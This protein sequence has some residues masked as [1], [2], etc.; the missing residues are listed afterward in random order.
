[1]STIENTIIARE[2][3][4]KKLLKDQKYNIDYYQREY[5]W[6]KEQITTLIDDLMEEFNR[7]YDDAHQRNNVQTYNY[8]YMGAVIFIKR[9]EDETA[10]IDGQQRLTSFTLLL[11]YL[12]H[13]LPDGEKVS[14]HDYIS[15]T[16]YGEKLFNLNIPSRTNCLEELLKNGDY[17]VRNDDDDSIQ[18]MMDRY[19][20]IVESESLPKEGDR[21][22]PFF[23]DW[24]TNKVIFVDIS[25]FKDDNAYMIFETMNDRG[26]GL[27]SVEMLKGYMIANVKKDERKHYD[28]KWKKTIKD[29]VTLG[30]GQ[31]GEF[32][33][34]WLRGKHA[35]TQRD[36]QKGSENQDFE[37]IGT[38]FHV[39]VRDNT[40]K[41]NT[42]VPN[43]FRELLENTIPFYANIFHDLTERL[44]GTKD[45]SRYYLHH[46]KPGRICFADSLL[47]PLFMAPIAL[48]D[49]SEI[50]EKKIELVAKYAEMMCVFKKLNRRSI[51]HNQNKFPIYK[52][53]L[54]IRDTTVEELAEI[55]K[56]DLMNKGNKYNLDAMEN[57]QMHGQ[58]KAFTRFLLQRITHHIE[59]QSE[60]PTS[61]SE[62]VT[63]SK[64]NP[65]EIEH[66]WADN[67]DN[68]KDEF[69]N[70]NEFSD[71]RN[72][73]GALL[74]LPKS[75]N[76]SYNAKPYNEKLKHF[77]K[78]NLLALSLHPDAY[79]HNSGFMRYIEEAGL[80][81]RH[82]PEFKK[83]DVL[84]RQ[85]LYRN[86][87]EEIWG[88][89]TLDKNL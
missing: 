3:T 8:Y 30:A 40:G 15:S 43:S 74:L 75:R 52:L 69:E 65:Y 27:T 73:L 23:L 63:S 84:E 41:M 71:F 33:K 36:Q 88:I 44:R 68:H 2:V 58:N 20:D 42:N 67:Y 13:S 51:A 59:E 35:E 32:F 18:N 77:T 1:M 21:K 16:Q 9:D 37:K 47:Y 10:I 78:E 4:L 49:N 81:F 66:L 31:D 29:L 46:L 22:L 7:N 87:G 61:L 39:W 38:R 48:G 56:N 60:Y 64:K 70:E 54:K 34:S 12:Q 14:I 85:K 72:R 76:S 79:K 89:H 17:T 5:I 24:L 83:Q 80:K 28:D 50:I 25:S 26:R 11:I 53:I 62:Y 6:G 82:H 86:I 57:F 19:K 45:N 55:L